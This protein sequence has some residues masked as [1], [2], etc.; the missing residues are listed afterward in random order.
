[1]SAPKNPN[2]AK[3]K[4]LPVG[5]ILY[6]LFYSFVN[7]ILPLAQ[8][9]QTKSFFSRMRLDSIFC[10]GRLPEYSQRMFFQFNDAACGTLNK[11]CE[12]VITIDPR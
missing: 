2:S 10:G 7:F 4:R 11:S 6:T 5:W 8:N 3:G 12:V 9:A 1:M